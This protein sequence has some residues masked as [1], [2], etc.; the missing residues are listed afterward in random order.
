MD[1]ASLLAKVKE[2][3]GKNPDKLDSGLDKASDLVKSE[4]P[5]V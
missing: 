1:V 5:W 2:W 3:I 4:P